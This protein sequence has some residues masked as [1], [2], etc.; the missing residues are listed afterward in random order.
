MGAGVGRPREHCGS[1]YCRDVFFQ[2]AY[3]YRTRVR[4]LEAKH[5]LNWGFWPKKSNRRGALEQNESG[6]RNF[7]SASGWKHPLAHKFT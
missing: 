7:S 3:T 4:R 1:N 5:S 2:P 6:R